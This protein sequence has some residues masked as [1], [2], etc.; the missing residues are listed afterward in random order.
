MILF[1]K[2]YQ[3]SLNNKRIFQDTNS[4]FLKFKNL[5][6]F[7]GNFG[8]LNISI[9]KTLKEDEIIIFRSPQ[10]L[11][12]KRKIELIR[13]HQQEI[14]SQPQNSLSDN[15][16]YLECWNARKEINVN[17]IVLFGNSLASIDSKNYFFHFTEWDWKKFIW[18]PK[19]WIESGN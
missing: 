13:P 17:Y 6:D 1:H 11:F 2:K 5:T 15:R 3:D 18:I 10:I 7:E 14:V 9:L 19:N 8:R 12:T 16:L 4:N